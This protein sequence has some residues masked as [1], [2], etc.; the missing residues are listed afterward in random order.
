MKRVG[1]IGGVLLAV[2]VVMQLVPKGRNHTNPPV[3]QEPAWPSPEV[4][5]LAVR[6]CFDCHSNETKWPWYASVAPASWLVEHHVEEGRGELNFSEFDKPQRHAK[7]AAEE[8]SEGEMPMAGYVALHGEAKLSEAEK[9][10][11][12]DAFSAM[13]PK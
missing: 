5:A 2:F 10:Q 1:V 3:A 9:K 4:R 12:V 13:F 6:A 8:V 7:D 11:L